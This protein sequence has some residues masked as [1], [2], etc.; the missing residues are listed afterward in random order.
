MVRDFYFGIFRL[1]EKEMRRK[2]GYNYISINKFWFMGIER[3]RENKFVED[4][5]SEWINSDL[6]EFYKI[7][8]RKKF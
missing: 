8:K 7:V 3:N 2:N 5:R 1:G 6:M 4:T